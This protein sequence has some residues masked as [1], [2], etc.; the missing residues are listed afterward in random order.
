M[1]ERAR[2]SGFLQEPLVTGRVADAGAAEDLEGHFSLQPWIPRSKHFSH[3]ACA[4]GR[5]NLIRPE[6]C[7]GFYRQF[8]GCADYTPVVYGRLTTMTVTA[9]EM[10][11]FPAASRATAVN[12]CGPFGA[13]VLFQ[14]IEYGARESSAPRFTPSSLN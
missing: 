11:V 9:L 14:L 6:A 4:E 3:A 7:A 10:V 8:F 12:V 2:R 1:I 5:L 13:V